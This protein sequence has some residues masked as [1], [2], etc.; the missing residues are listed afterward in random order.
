MNLMYMYM[1]FFDADHIWHVWKWMH[2]GTVAAYE[3][4][5]FHVSAKTKVHL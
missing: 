4:Q 3:L 1:V 2:F 5:P